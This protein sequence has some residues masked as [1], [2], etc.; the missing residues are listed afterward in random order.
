MELKTIIKNENWQTHYI[1]TKKKWYETLKNEVMN[2]SIV[3]CEYYT[4]KKS[5][6]PVNS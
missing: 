5:Y 3:R 6:E 4:P 1:H 2:Q